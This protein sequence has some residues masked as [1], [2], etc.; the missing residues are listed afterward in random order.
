[1][2]KKT[3]RR[4]PRQQ[5]GQRRIEKILAAAERVFAKVGYEAATTN[6]IARAARTSIGSVYQFFPHKEAILQAVAGRYVEQ[7]RALH[8][9][10][11][12]HQRL[13]E[14]LE[15][16]YERIIRTLAD[17]HAAHPGFQALFF[18]SATSAHLAAANDLLERECVARAEQLFAERFPWMTPADRR[19]Y[20][21]I[22]VHATKALL[23]L[24]ESGD[25]GFRERVLAEIKRL[26]LGHM[27]RVLAERAPAGL[28]APA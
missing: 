27:Q 10:L 23:P 17:F 3:L 8:A 11:F 18:G 4:Q 13:P 9:E 2:G 28:E 22:N 6:A 15:E 21:T 7:L 19:L 1:L 5:R 26:L 16:C 20:A 12:D 14:D 25:A 24:S